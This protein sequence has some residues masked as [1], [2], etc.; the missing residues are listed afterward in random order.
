MV[1]SVPTL[2]KRQQLVVH[3]P[4]VVPFTQQ[5]VVPMVR[6]NHFVLNLLI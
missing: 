1:V 3:Y 4:V 2:V 5:M 6:N